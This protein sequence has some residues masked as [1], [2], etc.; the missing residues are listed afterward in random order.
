M[1]IFTLK[2]FVLKKIKKKI[3]K[4]KKFVVHA[5]LIAVLNLAKCLVEG[6]QGLCK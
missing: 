4:I 6:A 2:K 3:K 5:V 1:S